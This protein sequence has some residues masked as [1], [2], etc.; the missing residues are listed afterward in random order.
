MK[1]WLSPPQLENLTI[2]W[3]NWYNEARTPGRK[4]ARARLFL[5]FLLA[6][7]GGL[8]LKETL[9]LDLSRDIDCVTGFLQVKGEF[10]RRILLPI[11][12]LRPIR[13]LLSLAEAQEPDF[14]K[15]DSS[16]IRKTF[17]AVAPEDLRA[18]ASPRSLRYARW[19]ELL[20]LHTPPDLAGQYLGLSPSGLLDLTKDFQETNTFICVIRSIETALVSTALTVKTNTD[21]LFYILCNTQEVLSSDFQE[22]MV[23]KAKIASERIFIFS[24]LE[25][26]PNIANI[27][28]G[29]IVSIYEDNFEYFFNIVLESGEELQI[30]Q[31][32][33]AMK[34]T[35]SVNQKVYAAFGARAPQIV[36]Y[37]PLI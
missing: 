21:I 6:R 12:S 13:R 4:I 22:G 24:S 8:R 28:E 35:F 15:L 23:V 33:I 19:G 20:A 9:G 36:S 30:Q 7:Y 18:M 11:N 34:E 5:I 37:Q 16:F 27:L 3:E 2:S 29:K 10:P 1:R 14:L 26:L 25:F 31:D 17:Y 32:K